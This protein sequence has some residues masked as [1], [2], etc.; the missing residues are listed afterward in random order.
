[1]VIEPWRKEVADELKM[2][3]RRHFSR[4]GYSEV[5]NFLSNFYLNLLCP[6]K[7]YYH[8]KKLDYPAVSRGPREDSDLL[9]SQT[10]GQF[11]AEIKQASIEAGIPSE[12]FEDPEYNAKTFL[13]RRELWNAYKILRS[14]GYNHTDLAS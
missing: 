9:K 12:I 6:N 4:S 11:Y 13:F 7:K 3:R 8:I 14:K 10:L 1:M 5:Y 2:R